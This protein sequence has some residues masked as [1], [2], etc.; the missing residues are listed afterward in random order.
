MRDHEIQYFKNMLQHKAQRQ[1][2]ELSL[3]KELGFE[4]SLRDGIGEL[5]SY[6]NHP[7]DLGS[8]TYEMEKQFALTKHSSKQIDEVN[9]ALERIDDG[10]YGSCEFCGSE[11]GF[12]RLNVLP[13]A[14]L[15][16]SCEEEDDAEPK[17]PAGIR[18]DRPIE[19]DL[20]ATPFSRT[21]TT[22]DSVIYDG[23]DALQE[24]QFYG[25]SS[26]PQD[27][28]VNENIDYNHT[29][30]ESFEDLGYVQDVES[31]SN[32]TYK[33]QLPDSHGNSFDGYV[34]PDQETRVSYFGEDEPEEP[35]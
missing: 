19:E 10:H 31:I 20:L 3:H 22:G 1:S 17:E 12:E 21:F 2:N 15:C 26:G 28:S 32:D 25:S 30:Y 33:Q 4:D 8:E 7:A 16:L 27:I 11:I 13:E 24:T 23:E 14:R 35:V 34:E 29:Y 9:A 6:D 18:R 5:S